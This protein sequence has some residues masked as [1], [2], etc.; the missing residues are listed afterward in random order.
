MAARDGVCEGGGNDSQ[1]T[2]LLLQHA[3]AAVALAV[4]LAT[5]V[6]LRITSCS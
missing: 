5:K 4:S 6:D 2:G 1:F 3:G